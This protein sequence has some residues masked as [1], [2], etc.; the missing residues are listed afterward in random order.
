MKNKWH[1]CGS[2]CDQVS[3][4]FRDKAY[5]VQ[6]KWEFKHHEVPPYRTISN[7]KEDKLG[8]IH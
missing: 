5:R 1:R 3:P 8:Q 2:S 4:S 6:P 7:Y